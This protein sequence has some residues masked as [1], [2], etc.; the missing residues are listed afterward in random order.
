MSI[1]SACKGIPS[2]LTRALAACLAYIPGSIGLPNGSKRLRW[3]RN[4][5]THEEDLQNLDNRGL[6]P[7]NLD[8]DQVCEGLSFSG[9]CSLPQ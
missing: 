4:N 9:Y 5:V 6:N 2:V 8:E 1:N 3:L 7:Y